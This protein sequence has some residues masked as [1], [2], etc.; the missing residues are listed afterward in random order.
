MILGVLSLPSTAPDIICPLTYMVD[1]VEITPGVL[2]NATWYRVPVWRVLFILN[3]LT[4][5]SNAG[6]PDCRVVD[7]H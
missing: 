2:V 3:L 5:K 6:L 1:V 7:N 4:Q